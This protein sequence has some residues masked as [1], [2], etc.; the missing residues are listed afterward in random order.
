M[1]ILVTGFRHFD[2]EKLS[3]RRLL[4]Q[5]IEKGTDRTRLQTSVFIA[6][7][8]MDEQMISSKTPAAKRSFDQLIRKYKDLLQDNNMYNEVS[9]SP[10][11][12]L[13]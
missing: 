3:G 6:L 12:C 4:E 10:P 1:G 11:L 13:F 9:S 5:Y 8:A 2:S 7:H